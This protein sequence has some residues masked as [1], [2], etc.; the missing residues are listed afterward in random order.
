MSFMLFSSKQLNFMCGSNGCL[1][2]WRMCVAVWSQ[3]VLS[4]APCLNVFLTF[5]IDYS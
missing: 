4:V 5:M 2:V 3:T 1:V